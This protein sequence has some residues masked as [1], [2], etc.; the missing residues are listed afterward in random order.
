LVWCLGCGR[1]GCGFLILQLFCD[2]VLA[3]LGIGDTNTE[4]GDYEIRD[5]QT[6]FEKNP[7]RKDIYLQETPTHDKFRQARNIMSYSLKLSLHMIEP[8]HLYL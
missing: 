8:Q 7:N 6:P 4:T 2:L 1:G 3:R 5:M